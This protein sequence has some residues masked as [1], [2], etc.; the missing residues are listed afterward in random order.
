MTTDIVVASP[1]LDITHYPEHEAILLPLIFG[2]SAGFP[3]PAAD[4]I[5]L[6]IDLGK[7]IVKNRY[8]T[9]LGRVKGDSMQDVHIDNGDIIVID[10]GKTCK[11]GDI[12]VC[13][14]DGEHIVKR[15]IFD[16]DGYW[17]VPENPEYKSIRVTSANEFQIWGV[18]ISVIKFL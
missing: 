15:V 5:D 3:S 14:L 7:L 12:A 8:T 6:D 1:Y 4:Y 9:F 16:N 13:V 2:L 18:V 11:S 17:L 10:K